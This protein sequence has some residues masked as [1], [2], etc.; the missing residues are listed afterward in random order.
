[1]ILWKEQSTGALQAEGVFYHTEI[2]MQE[3]L[4]TLARKS[5]Q[6]NLYLGFP[7]Q[8]HPEKAVHTRPVGK[9][10]KESC[11][12]YKNRGLFR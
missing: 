5:T 8:S 1:M 10:A 11:I 3:L 12:V 6:P 4:I 2:K 7:D 9:G